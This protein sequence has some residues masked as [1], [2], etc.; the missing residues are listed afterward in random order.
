MAPLELTSLRL[1]IWGLLAAAAAGAAVA[2]GLTVALTNTDDGIETG[3]TFTAPVR[4]YYGP[5]GPQ[6]HVLCFSEDRGCGTPLLGDQDMVIESGQDVT[7]T[8]VFVDA[9][10]GGEE[11]RLAFYVHPR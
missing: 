8:E 3:D 11:Q 9:V 4:S 5:E 1:T 7:V 10:P 6:P 2:T